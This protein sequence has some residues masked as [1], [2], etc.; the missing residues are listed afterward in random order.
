ML[1]FPLSDANPFKAVTIKIST[2][3]LGQFSCLT[4]SKKTATFDLFEDTCF[5]SS[6]HN[7]NY[8]Q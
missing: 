2:I 7:N 5:N 4:T 8:L 3:P 1:T 6:K